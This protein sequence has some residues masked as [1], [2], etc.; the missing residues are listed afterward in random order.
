MTLTLP[1]SILALSSSCLGLHPSHSLDDKVKAAAKHGLSG[2]E[3]NIEC[4]PSPLKD[5]PNAARE[6]INLARVLR[7]EYVQ[8]PV[9]FG[10]DASTDKAVIVSELQQ[11]ADLGAAA[12][13]IVDIAYEPVG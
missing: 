9:Q 1:T 6:W 2:I 3:K 5:R 4:H 13:P 7:A 10:R 11:L 8:V 12:E